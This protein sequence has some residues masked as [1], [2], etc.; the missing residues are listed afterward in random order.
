ARILARP[1]VGVDEVDADRVGLDQD[2]TRPGGGRGLLDVGED[3]WPAG[4][5]DFDG[6]HDTYHAGVKLARPDLRHPS[7]VL[8]GCSALIEGDGDDAGL[9]GALRARGLHAR[10]LAWDDPDT[11]TADLVILRATWDYTE[12]LSDFLAWTRRVP[13]LL[14]P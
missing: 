2:L 3:F 1:E 11:E 4:F 13:N 7:I 5:G 6:V 14:N 10:W 9:V 12:R 8:A